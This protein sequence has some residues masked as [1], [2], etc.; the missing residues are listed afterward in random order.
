MSRLWVF[1]MRLNGAIFLDRDGTINEDAGY[2]HKVSDWIWRPGAIEGLQKFC[3]AGWPLIVVSNQ[4]GIGR[5]YYS[6]ATLHRLEKWLD[7]RLAENGV[8]I[9]GWFYCP[10]LP[11]DNC[12]CRKPKPGLLLEA[13][14]KLDIDLACSWMLGD[15][16]SDM[17]AGES[18]GCRRG[19]ITK[20]AEGDKARELGT[21]FSDV[22]VW[23][24]LSSAADDIIASSNPPDANGAG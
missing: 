1:P 17:Q 12:S 3:S 8:K 14:K 21:L 18:A 23:D 10:H 6:W 5:G 15:K 4:S 19:L 16:A 22:R 13:A 9:A 20:G 24:N 2:T 7:D 11:E